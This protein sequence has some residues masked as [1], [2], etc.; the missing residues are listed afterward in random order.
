MAFA[1]DQDVL[2]KYNGKVFSDAF[3]PTVTGLT[4]FVYMNRSGSG[5]HSYDYVVGQYLINP[6]KIGGNKNNKP[7]YV[8]TTPSEYKFKGQQISIHNQSLANK[9]VKGYIGSR[10]YIK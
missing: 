8:N 5:K 4:D 7:I 2:K 9:I 10:Y 6:Y 1:V 3:S